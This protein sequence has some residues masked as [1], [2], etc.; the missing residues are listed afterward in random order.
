MGAPPAAAIVKSCV[1]PSRS[2]ERDALAIGRP[3]RRELCLA[4]EAELAQALV[5]DVA[6]PKVTARRSARN[7]LANREGQSGRRGA[8]TPGQRVA[9]ASGTTP[10]STVRWTLQA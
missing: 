5:G 6:D 4:G 2:E 3:V 7:R 9:A 1:P 8:R 10:V